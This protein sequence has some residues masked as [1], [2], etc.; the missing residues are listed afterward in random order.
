MI[1]FDSTSGTRTMVDYSNEY[2][3][4]VKSYPL[5]ALEAYVTEKNLNL[6]YGHH[7]IDA[8]HFNNFT[9]NHIAET[10]EEVEIYTPIDEYFEENWFQLTEDFYNH[11]N[12]TEHRA[13]N[14]PQKTLRQVG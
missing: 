8:L 2:G 1:D 9:Q 7:G 12:P 4:V 13:N 10:V 3:Q 6:S 14:T 5:S 11:K